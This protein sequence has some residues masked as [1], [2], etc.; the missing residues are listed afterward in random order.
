MVARAPRHSW[1]MVSWTCL[2][3]AHPPSDSLQ[4]LSLARKPEIPKRQI[5]APTPEP[6]SRRS[7][8]RSTDDP[9]RPSNGSSPTRNEPSQLAATGEAPR[10]GMRH[11]SCGGATCEAMGRA[12]T[13]DAQVEVERKTVA[14]TTS[15]GSDRALHR[16]RA[17][18]IRPDGSYVNL[19][20]SIASGW[21][22]TDIRPAGGPGAA[23]SGLPDG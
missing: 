2:G 16:T 19:K 8:A 1:S 11:H 22:R 13:W 6:I 15:A 12:A 10:R 7:N 20:A 9:V 4:I 23:M 17:A 5:C 14:C 3:R 21:G 18:A